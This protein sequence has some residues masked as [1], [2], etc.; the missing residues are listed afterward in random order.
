MR[1]KNKSY[2]ILEKIT[3]SD[4]AAEGKCLA[5]HGEIV[6]FIEGIVAPDDVVDLRV[7]KQKKNF[8]EAQVIKIHEASSQRTTPF[9]QHFGVCG[10]CKWQHIPYTTQLAQKQ[11]QVTDNLERIGKIH[12]PEIQPILPSKETTYY[13][14]K[15]EYTFS[16]NRWLTDEDMQKGEITDRTALGF[17]IP[18]RFDKILDIETCYLQP[19]PSNKIRLAVREFARQNNYPFFDLVKQEGFLRNLIIRTTTTS[20]LMVIVQVFSKDEPKLYALLDFLRDT[21][22]AITSLQYVINSKGNET[23]HDLEVVT[24]HGK[25]YIT[26]KMEDLEFR[27]G[28][29]SFYQTNAEQ[30]LE[31][32]KIARNYADLKGDELVY[33]LYTGTGTIANFVARQARKVVGLEYVP[34]AI[35]DAKINSEVNGISNTEFFAG[36]MKDLLTEDFLQENGHPDV[37]ITDP[38]RA[39]MDAKV[40]EM[41]LKVAPQ[42][43]VYVSCNP[44]TQARDLALLDEK[45]VVMAVQPVDMF[46]HTYHV[47]NV[48]WLERRPVSN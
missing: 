18:K 42:R 7:F 5:R 25:S 34:M 43:I 33:D 6:V 4:F 48:A 31:L 27:V 13:R 10:G 47:E 30:A 14:N 21:F 32:Y 3:V 2:P 26:E 44:A 20:E 24:Y 29:K 36:D 16:S 9:C 39:G 22:P 28:P 35:E 45:Y 37:V 23:F 11:D 15:L 12:L 46:P 40:V 17:H 19:D 41:L 8:W 1:K 38:P